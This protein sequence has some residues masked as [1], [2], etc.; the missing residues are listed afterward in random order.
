MGSVAPY[1][2]LRLRGGVWYGGS[3]SDSD[4]DS[5]YDDSDDK[6]AFISEEDSQEEEEA[7]KKKI[8]WDDV[9][10]D[11]EG[12]V[13]PLRSMNFGRFRDVFEERFK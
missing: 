11:G 9:K 10:N 5:D 2:S 6:P 7:E 13:I 4:D 1:P 8:L 3:R 12:A